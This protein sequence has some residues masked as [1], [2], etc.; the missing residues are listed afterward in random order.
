MGAYFPHSTRHGN[1]F[2][3]LMVEVTMDFKCELWKENGVWVIDPVPEEFC[4]TRMADA[5]EESSNRDVGIMISPPTDE[6]TPLTVEIVFR[7]GQESFGFP[8]KDCPF[9]H[10]DYRIIDSRRLTFNQGKS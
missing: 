1:A 6:E 7:D 2:L 10:E 4:C 8:L 9:C 5:W 3:L